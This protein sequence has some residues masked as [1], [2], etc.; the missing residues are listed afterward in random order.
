[1]KSA[2]PPP[3][4]ISIK[5]FS[6]PHKAPLFNRRTSPASA[7]HVPVLFSLLY[8]VSESESLDLIAVGMELTLILLKSD[9]GPVLLHSLIINDPTNFDSTVNDLVAL[10]RNGDEKGVSE[11]LSLLASISPTCSAR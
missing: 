5:H 8:L 4:C 2:P 11:T 6:G 1:M 9:L 7:D 10:Y 3:H